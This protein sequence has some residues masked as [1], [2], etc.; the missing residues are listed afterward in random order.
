MLAIGNVPTAMLVYLL[1]RAP[2]IS[3]TPQGLEV[4]AVSL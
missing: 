2:A 3:A 4:A 1:P